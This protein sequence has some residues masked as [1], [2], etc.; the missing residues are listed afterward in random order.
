[1]SL[2][3]DQTLVLLRKDECEQRRLIQDSRRRGAV[4]IFPFKA[5]LRCPFNRRSPPQQEKVP[6]AELAP[7]RPEKPAESFFQCVPC[8]HASKVYRSAMRTACVD[9]HLF[10][11]RLKTLDLRH[12]PFPESARGVCSTL[13]DEL[14]PPPEAPAAARKAGA[15]LRE[16]CGP[17]AWSAMP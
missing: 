17:F 1:M 4:G 9:Y 16:G 2:M 11:A 6:A 10:F 8:A 14:D 3:N 15:F 13:I 12:F 5:T 7:I